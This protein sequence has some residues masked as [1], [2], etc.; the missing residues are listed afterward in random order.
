MMEIKGLDYNTSRTP[1]LQPEYGREIQK[2]IDYALTLPTKDERQRCAEEIVRL[3]G[4]K[5]PQMHGNANYEQMLW[6]HLYIMSGKALDID[7]PYDVTGAEKICKKPAPMKYTQAKDQ[8]KLRHYG[9]L[10]EGVFAKLAAM[11]EGPERDELA[12]LTANQMK[13]DLA[14]WGHGSADEEKV[15]SDI[16][17]FTDGKIQFDPGT[18]K[19]DT[20]RPDRDAAGYSKKKRR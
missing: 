11:P 16:A 9:H 5:V 13:N 18:F 1:L 12:R 8:V 19:F 10:L 14:T 4:T 15:I 17:R 3:M 6:D 2:M 20:V 7:W